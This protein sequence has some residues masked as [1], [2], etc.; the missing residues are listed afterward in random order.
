MENYQISPE[1]L[2][3]FLDNGIGQAVERHK[4]ELTTPAREYLVEMLQSFAEDFGLH[5]DAFGM[6]ITFQ[7]QRIAE[8]TNRLRQTQLQR[9][10][11]DHCLFLVGYFY[12][13]VQ[14][15]GEGMVQYHSQIGSHAYQ[16]TGKRPFMEVGQKFNDLYLVIGD[17]H[18]PAI[19][20]KRLVEIYER[21]EKTRDKYYA[22]LLL[23]KGIVPKKIR[24]DTN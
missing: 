22:S 1:S 13:F 6:P 21:W 17:L 5:R 18:L 12:D 8:E 15:G 10:L 9:E 24:K 2:A 23:G 3:S 19:D 20:E 11:G 7:Y 4:L 16:Q 14:R